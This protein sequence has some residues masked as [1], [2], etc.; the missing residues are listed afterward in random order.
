MAK[1]SPNA[2]ASLRSLLNIMADLRHPETGCAW[3]IKQTHASI[4]PYTIEEAYEVAEAVESGN[5]NDLRDELGD[6]LL[7]VVFQARIG[8][9]AGHFD[10]ASIADSI[11]EKMTRRH[12]H[13]FG[14]VT[15]GSEAEQREAWETIKAEERNDKDEGRLLD[16]VA[17][18]LPPMTRAV[19]LQKRAARVGFDWTE[20][21]P[22]IDK[23]YEELEEVSA[24]LSASAQNKDRIEDE[25]GD[26]LFAVINLA[27]KS[28]IDPDAALARTNSKFTRR[29]NAI[30]DLATNQNITLNDASL[31]MMENW[32]TQIKKK[33]KTD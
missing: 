28:K 29:F 3:D 33:E 6:L 11:S 4:V 9:E 31:E 13:I 16:G 32:W 10:F 20:P 30:E 22:V 12:P 24:E 26:L 2:E 5:S 1:N 7:Q 8:E 23:V 18:T 15:Y 17:K 19:K 21:E 25:I 14:D 27:R